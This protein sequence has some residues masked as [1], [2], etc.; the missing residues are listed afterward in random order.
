[1]KWNLDPS[2]SSIEFAVRHMG[3][4]TVRGRF[5]E[6]DAEIES[7][8]EGAPT[9]VELTI[10]V[11]SITTGDE[12]R[13]NHLRSGDFFDVEK[14]PKIRFV[15]TNVEEQGDSYQLEGDLTIRGTTKPVTLDVDLAPARPDPFG[16][17]RAAVVAEGEI[18]RKD[19]GL[20]WNQ[21]LEAG[22]LL[23]AE[24]VKMSID[25]QAIAPLDSAQQGAGKGAEAA[26]A[27]R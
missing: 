16:N 6:F 23:V 27:S 11:A 12:N 20:T 4:S 24:K 18:N 10:D 14:H 25:L 19:W 22:A 21:V 8:S 3:L 15:S 26:S 7:D 2:H 9:H 17:L 13:D 5:T 1:M